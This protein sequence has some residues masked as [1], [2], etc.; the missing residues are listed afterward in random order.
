MLARSLPLLILFGLPIGLMKET[1][2]LAQEQRSPTPRDTTRSVATNH[3]ETEELQRLI[4]S[5]DELTR[6]IERLRKSTGQPQQIVTHVKVL[7]LSLTKA[8]AAEIHVDGIDSD[9]LRTRRFGEALSSGLLDA[10]PRAEVVAAPDSGSDAV[11]TK[12]LPSEDVLQKLFAELKQI[13]ALKVLAEPSVATT[14]GRS[15]SLR[16]GGEYPIPVPQPN[17][18]STIEFK[19]FGTR[20]DVVP[21]ILGQGRLRLEVRPQISELDF[22]HTVTIGDRKV[23]G[24]RV[25]AVDT[26]VEMNLGETLVLAGLVQH[27][28]LREPADA[29]NTHVD[30]STAVDG[31]SDTDLKPLEKS[32]EIELIVTVRAEVS[33]AEGTTKSASP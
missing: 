8:R 32:E 20:L 30:P 2:A 17:G 4:R 7:E 31:N 29:G 6:E 26:A 3:L 25:R 28:T 14:S 13:G 21:S 18:D 15:A 23:P 10:S 11:H 1:N 22:N 33:D 27:R 24:F 9:C 5:R 19:E 12:I 16:M